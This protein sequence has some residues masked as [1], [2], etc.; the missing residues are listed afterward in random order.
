MENWVLMADVHEH[1]KHITTSRVGVIELLGTKT[2]KISYKV[3]A[4]DLGR[5]VLQ[6]LWT[7]EAVYAPEVNI[8]DLGG[9][10]GSDFSDRG[11]RPEPKRGQAGRGRN[12]CR[13][14]SQAAQTEYLRPEAAVVDA[15]ARQRRAPSACRRTPPSRHARIPEWRVE[16]RQCKVRS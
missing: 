10:S 11:S 13:D 2:A 12:R 7:A 8:A 3:L 1:C 6:E 9:R 16:G 14:A 15:R 4:P 5:R